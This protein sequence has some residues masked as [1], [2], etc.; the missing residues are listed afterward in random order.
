MKK[1][2]LLIHGGTTFESY[3]GYL[4][5]LNSKETSIEKLTSKD[6]KQNLE[7]DLGPNFLV[8]APRMPNPMNSRYVEWK[9]WFEKMFAL[10][11][12][13]PIL[14]GHSLVQYF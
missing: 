3:E 5:Y 1:Q 6:W 4:Q 9:I 12:E 13:N 10:L 2:V 14:I 11:D 8:I 7:H